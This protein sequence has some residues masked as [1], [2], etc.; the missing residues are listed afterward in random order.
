MYSLL[1]Y[2]CAHTH[3]IYKHMYIYVQLTLEQHGFELRGPTYTQIFL[4]KYLCC[5]RFTVGSP[6]TRRVTE[7][8]ILH[9]VT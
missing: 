5:V 1:K 8:P 6:Q 2:V 3:T 9:P 4:N 7:Y